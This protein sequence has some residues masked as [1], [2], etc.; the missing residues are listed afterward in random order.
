[1]RRWSARRPL[2]GGFAFG[3]AS[4]VCAVSAPA[5]EFGF[6]SLGAAEDAAARIM[7]ASGLRADFEIRVK[8]GSDNAVAG[9][10]LSCGNLRM[11]RVIEYDPEF[12]RY[13]ERNTDR[14]GPISVMAHEV[15]HHL[16][17]HTV[18]GEGSTPPNE[19]DADFYSGFILQQ[20][21]ASLESA[22]ATMRLIGDPIGSSSH[23]PQR[24]RLQAIAM[25]WRKAAAAGAGGG[26]AGAALDA[27]R[28]ELEAELE[29][30]RAELRRLEAELADSTARANDAEA[31]V[32]AAQTALA[33]AEEA[34]RVL[35]A[36]G[37]ASDADI[38]AAEARVRD[39]DARV[40]AAQTEIQAAQAAQAAA[41]EALA[42][43]EAANARFGEQAEAAAATADRALLL[44]ALLV[45]L[46][47]V[48]L[49]LS[50][51][52]PR[53]QVVRVMDRASR[54][55]RRRRWDDRV[56][57][58]PQPRPERAPRPPSPPPLPGPL[59]PAPRFDGSGPERCAEPGGFVLGRAGTL[60]DAVVDHQS[61]SRRHARLT[62]VDGRLCVEDLNSTNGTRVNGRRLDPFVPM[63]I[64][65]EDTVAVGDVNLAFRSE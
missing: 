11:C 60:V 2:A 3:L 23:P 7:E 48:A 59:P 19:L 54:S 18:F 56:D 10:A 22:Q 15:A 26:S 5:Q 25:G 4:L 43:A 36:R 20:L 58:H 41:E 12:L 8:E 46:V 16:Q 6:R 38:R 44:T 34:L 50:L 62:R 13:I 27:A 51:H 65:R 1:M 24:E 30:M 47:L 9:I 28:A 61:V 32:D 21:G 49:V 29:A 55:F 63:A 45:P 17:G 40:R 14:W 53:R 31:H 37:A 64:T 42:D 57:P 52:K 33:E 35:R 39:A